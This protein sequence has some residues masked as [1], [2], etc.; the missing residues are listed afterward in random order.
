MGVCVAI[1]GGA[2]LADGPADEVI[3]S[4]EQRMQRSLE[5]QP[6]APAIQSA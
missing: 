4:Y 5:P 1:D 3:A 2:L 6:P